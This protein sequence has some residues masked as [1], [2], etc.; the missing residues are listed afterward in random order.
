MEQ[1]RGPPIK[2]EQVAYWFFRLNG[3]MNIVNF[4]VHHE[5]RGREGTEVDILAVRLPHRRELAMSGEP[6]RDH[7]I[8][9][10]DGQIDVIIAEV[11]T[12]RCDL[13]GPWTDP[14]KQNMHR[15]LY[16]LG[17]FPEDQVSIVADSLYERQFYANDQFRVRLFA[18]GQTMNPGLSAQVVQLTW[19]QILTFIYERLKRYWR[20]KAQHRQW[21]RHG[22]L[23][24]RKQGQHRTAEGFVQ[25]ILA[26]MES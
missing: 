13:N 25:D 1:R 6:M 20:I 21:D 24:Y 5:Q 15:V 10:S 12:G 14:D 26:R 2:T 19:E 23:L 18:V 3:C 7:P 8:F 4:L 11:K 17:A 9:D 16:A 22:E